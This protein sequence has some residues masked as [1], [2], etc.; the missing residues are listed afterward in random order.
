[1]HPADTTL[2]TKGCN[3]GFRA[4]AGLWDVLYGPAF[5]HWG[6]PPAASRPASAPTAE[7]ADPSAAPPV[8]CA[9]PQARVAVRLEP[10]EAASTVTVVLH[11]AQRLH[12]TAISTAAHTGARSE[13]MERAGQASARGVQRD[14]DAEAA[15]G[16]ALQGCAGERAAQ[17]REGVVA[18]TE[19]AAACEGLE[20]TTPECGKV[21]SDP[22]RA[23]GLLTLGY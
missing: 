19:H 10:D 23:Q 12:P 6:G 21:C 8:A 3:N 16:G 17:V 22:L 20:D 13:H 4:C 5:L 11:A 7:G 9:T 15:A 14:R 18:L 1:M 2:R